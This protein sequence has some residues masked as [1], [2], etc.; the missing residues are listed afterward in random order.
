MGRKEGHSDDGKLHAPATESDRQ[1]NDNREFDARGTIPG[2]SA[3]A[4]SC[5]IYALIHSTCFALFALCP[6]QRSFCVSFSE[7]GTVYAVDSTW[8]TLPTP[9]VRSIVTRTVVFRVQLVRAENNFIYT[10]PK[11]G[12]AT[13]YNLG[14]IAWVI[15]ATALVW[16]MI[17]GVGFFY[18]GLLRRKNALSM[19]WASMMCIGVVS[20]EVRCIVY[21]LHSPVLGSVFFYSGSSG[22]TRSRSA[23]G[24]ARTLVTLV[25]AM[26][27]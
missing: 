18:S 4:L 10:D 9:R 1:D 14:D 8:Q 2:S 15:A 25:R 13:L 24:A 23:T 21:F 19:I 22:V 5:F 7:V 6:H 11:T 20:F 12:V 3:R 16:L 26:S 27:S 17:P